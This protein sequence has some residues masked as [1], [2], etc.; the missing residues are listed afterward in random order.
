MMGSV[1]KVVIVAGCESYRTSDFL[2]AAALLRLE[3]I[4]ATDAPP[5]I[6]DTGGHLE[7]E[8]DDPERAAVQIVDAHPGAAAVIAVDDGGV[9]TAAIAAKALELPHNRP[10]AVAATKDKLLMRRLLDAAGVAQPRFAEASRG[11]VPDAAIRSGFPAV[12]KPVGLSASRGVIRVDTVAEARRAES[13]IRDILHAAGRDPE[14]KL[15][16]EEYVPGAEIAIEGL[17]A[18]GDLQVLAVIDKPD[19]LEGPFFEE[20]LFVTPSRHAVDVQDA[21]VALA[22]DAAR[23]LGL[24]MG[25]IHAEIRIAPEGAVQ[26]IEIAA[27][28]IGGLCGRSL[29]FGLLD[30]SLEVMVLRNALGLSG[31]DATASRP[32]SGVLMLPIPASGTLTDVENI[33]QVEKI[34]GV[35]EVAMTV[36]NG[37]EVQALPEGD[38][39]LGFV[40]ASGATP[41]DVESTLREA[42]ATLTVTI[43]GEAI[44]IR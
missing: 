26:V 32:A 38:R 16:V 31:G 34:A 15:L 24:E 33:S 20:T 1:N 5:P 13:R 42:M 39:Y 11:E 40:M 14:E 28:S 7:I 30:E 4:V 21:A 19:P 37:R 22:H 25:P 8:L 41:E 9:Q 18:D 6:E 23:A 36:V 12:V 3:T 35:D 43:D 44:P 17:L 29:G 27:R 10:E 2:S